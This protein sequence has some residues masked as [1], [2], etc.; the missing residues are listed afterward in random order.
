MALKTRKPT[1]AA[2]APLILIEGAEKSGKSW[3]AAAF[4]ASDKIGATYW[5]D[6]GEGSADEYGAIPG[7]RYEIVEHNGTFRE[8]FLAVNEVR[9]VAKAALDAGEKPVCLVIDSMSAEWELLKDMASNAQRR[10]LEIRASRSKNPVHIPGPDEE[11][12]PDTDIWNEVTARHYKLMRILMTFPGIVVITARGKEVVAMDANG[13]PTKE[14]VYKV[15]G[16][17]NLAYDVSLWVQMARGEDPRIMGGRST[18]VD[19]RPGKWDPKAMKDL[20]VERM[21]FEILSYDPAGGQTR[22]L[23][24]P[25][26]EVDNTIALDVA[27]DIIEANTREELT[28]IWQRLGALVEGG[29]LD[30]AEAETLATTIKT[31]GAKLAAAGDTAQVQQPVSSAPPESLVKRMYALLGKAGLNGDAQREQKIAY[32]SEI[33]GYPVSSTKD[34]STDEVK[35]I[36]FD[37]E[38]K[39][40]TNA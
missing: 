34:L 24:M 6:L 39:A 37:L 15:E 33:V 30:R 7:A 16:Q 31:K 3:A 10:R 13:R 8:I 4:S 36:I 18:K 35:A 20:T 11:C 32:F 28:T 22:D 21:V 2:S 19:L 27:A 12:K 40:G 26:G 29:E 5:I 17:K 38:D 14:K 25:D 23:V 9:A 1:G